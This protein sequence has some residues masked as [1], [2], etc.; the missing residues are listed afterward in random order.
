MQHSVDGGGHVVRCA[1]ARLTKESLSDCL[2]V[3]LPCAQ[4]ALCARPPR[5]DVS[6]FIS[7]R[8]F[9][10]P[11][12]LVHTGGRSVPFVRTLFW[13]NVAPQEVISACRVISFCGPRVSSFCPGH[14]EE[15]ICT[16]PRRHARINVNTKH[17]VV[18]L[19]PDVATTD[20]TAGAAQPVCHKHWW[21]LGTD[22][23][24]SKR[25]FHVR[26]FS[27]P[28]CERQ[29][30]NEQQFNRGV[31]TECHKESEW[32]VSTAASAH[33]RQRNTA[34]RTAC[35]VPRVTVDACRR[36]VCFCRS[37]KR[38]DGRHWSLWPCVPGGRRCVLWHPSHYALAR[39]CTLVY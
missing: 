11:I 25:C 37:R 19:V 10:C 36:R 29:E 1:V 15:A 3:W 39:L 17:A 9:E 28:K 32:V 33:G 34:A 14:C 16:D 5:W 26:T 30:A 7:S 22:I 6:H 18:S 20:A 24:K 13:G 31:E 8:L 12:G 2:I 4:S 35:F 38:A 27:Q 23:A 21:L